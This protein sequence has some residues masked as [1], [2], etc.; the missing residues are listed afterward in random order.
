MSE[1]EKLFFELEARI[2]RLKEKT[3]KYGEEKLTD[4][5]ILVLIQDFYSIL[6]MVDELRIKTKNPFNKEATND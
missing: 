1:N 2:V 3:S 5:E 6:D 4:D